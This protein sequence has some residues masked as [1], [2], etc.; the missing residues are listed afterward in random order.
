M[1]QNTERE[2]LI[3]KVQKLLAMAESTNHIEESKTFRNKAADLMAKY[4]IEN[5]E[6]QSTP[7][8]MSVDLDTDGD[9]TEW[10][11]HLVNGVCK[12]NGMLCIIH[13]SWNGL[14]KIKKLRLVGTASDHAA[15]TY[16]YDNVLQQ[17]GSALCVR[18]EKSRMTQRDNTKFLNGFAYG[19]CDKVNSL[20]AARNTKIQEY[21]L[22]KIDE[23]KSVMNWYEKE[24]GKLNSSKKSNA[25]YEMDGINAGRNARLNKG[26]NGSTG[27]SSVLRLN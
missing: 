13:S 11:I 18:A 19:L 3:D 22:V 2:Q 23:V 12:F 14:N 9:P 26:V 10:Q 27:N 16:M 4:A 17:M 24:Q 15:F 1:N 25:A 7:T 20:L 6:F 8:Y 21:G 5:S